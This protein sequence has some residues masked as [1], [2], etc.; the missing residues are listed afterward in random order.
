MSEL[1]VT[2]SI[3]SAET[4]VSLSRTE[5][6]VTLKVFTPLEA[7]RTLPLVRQIVSDV[8]TRGQELL[9]LH[10]KPYPDHED[11]LRAEEIVGQLDAHFGE[12]DQIGCTFR[13]PNFEVGLVD[14]PGLI[15]GELVHLCW[16]DDEE[17]LAF[18]HAPEAG[19]AGRLPIPPS[20]LQPEGDRA[21]AAS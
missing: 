8:L 2:H 11:R 21:G 12:L 17:T 18:Y 5:S 3:G 15:D 19:F 1:Q 20:L 14:F 4:V 13:C 10:R 16:R 9:A 6:S 7:T